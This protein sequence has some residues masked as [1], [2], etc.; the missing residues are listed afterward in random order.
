MYKKTFRHFH[1]L[2]QACTSPKSWKVEKLGQNFCKYDLRIHCTMNRVSPWASNHPNVCQGSSETIPDNQIGIIFTFDSRS[3]ISRSLPTTWQ[4]F[5]EPYNGNMNDPRDPDLKWKMSADA[6]IGLLC[7]EFKICDNRNTN[8]TKNGSTNIAM[9]SGPNKSLEAQISNTKLS[10]QPYCDHCKCVD[11]WMSRCCKNLANRKKRCF[12]C[13]KIG[14][15]ARDCKAKKKEKDKD[16]EKARAK[17]N[18]I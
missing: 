18:Q 15:F 6:F 17:M 1:K 2:V 8:G 5:I 12:I 3:I 7:K 16:K 13:G 14:H 4:T 11:H 10:V 9:T